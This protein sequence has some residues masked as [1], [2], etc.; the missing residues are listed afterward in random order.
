[1]RSDENRAPPGDPESQ[2]SPCRRGPHTHESAPDPELTRAPGLEFGLGRR[3]MAD[4]ARGHHED[5][6]LGNVRGM[7]ADAF[8]M[9]R[10]EDQIERGFHGHCRRSEEHTSELQSLAYL[11]CRLLL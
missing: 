3:L 2:D 8:E 9:A 6:V 4:V 11:V 10:D 1:M 7:V 5:D